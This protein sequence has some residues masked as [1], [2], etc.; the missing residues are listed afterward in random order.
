MSRK[1]WVIVALLGAATT[2]NYIDRQTLSILSPLLRR[3]LHLTEQD[4]SNVVTAFLISYT[5]MYSVGGRIMDAIGVRVGLSLSLAWWS[6]ATMLTG[7]ARSAASLS[8]FR[9]LLGIGE[10]CVFPAG[11]KVCGEWFPDRLRATAAGIFSSGSTL[12]A[13]L[14]PPVIAWITLRFGWRYAFLIPGCLGMLWLPLWWSVYRPAPGVVEREKPASGNW[15]GLLRE[16]TVWGLVLARLLSDPVWYFY[17]FW[18]PDYLQRERHL[19]LAEIGM[20]GWIPF[21]FADLGSLGGGIASDVLVRR[22]VAPQRARLIIL[23]GIAC[24]APLGALA[25]VIGSTAG[26][27]AVMC[28]V[29][30]LTQCWSTNTATLVADVLPHSSTATTMGLMG[31]AGSL[32]GACFAQVLAWVIGK[33]GYPAAFGLVALLHP[34]AA[35]ILLVMLRPLWR[36]RMR[37]ING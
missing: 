5:V 9:F 19:S 14:A 6:V 13:I 23:T 1:R 17:L 36:Q 3:E 35:A 33:S 34:C 7:F 18:L 10:P 8:L 16:R 29:A 32:A 21:L 28:V 25:G 15:R 4:Y 11:V 31:T 20:Y 2:I 30:C 27:I 22:G 24:F 12:G 26:A 37:T